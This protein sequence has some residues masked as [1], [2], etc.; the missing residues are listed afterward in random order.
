L[1]QVKG[2]K[3]FDSSIPKMGYQNLQFLVDLKSR[4]G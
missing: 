3:P 1:L 2:T 4:I